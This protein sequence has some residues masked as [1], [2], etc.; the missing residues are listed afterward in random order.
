MKNYTPAMTDSFG[1]ESSNNRSCNRMNNRADFIRLMESK[2]G[3]IDLLINSL[4]LSHQYYTPFFAKIQA[5]L[6]KIAF[7][8]DY[9][10]ELC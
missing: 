8:V 1:R 5:F 4:K 10:G 2:K 7:F 9:D 3:N 6:A